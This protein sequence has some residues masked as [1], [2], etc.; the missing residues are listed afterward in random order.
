[1]R[2]YFLV[3]KQMKE[4][5]LYIFDVVALALSG[6]AYIQFTPKEN[7]EIGEFR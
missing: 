1:V 2:V 5:L 3:E 6:K 4:Y 7:T